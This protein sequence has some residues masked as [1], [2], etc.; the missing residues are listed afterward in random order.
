MSDITKNLLSIYYGFS[1]EVDAAKTLSVHDCANVLSDDTNISLVDE[2]LENKDQISTKEST[3][4]EDTTEHYEDGFST[5]DEKSSIDDE[6]VFEEDD[7]LTE[8]VDIFE[9]LQEQKDSNNFKKDSHFHEFNV[10]KLNNQ[11][12]FNTENLIETSSYPEKL[13]EEQ[14][15]YKNSSS[16][17]R[18]SP[19]KRASCN[20]IF[21]DLRGSGISLFPED[22]FIQFPNL[23]ML[24]LEGNRLKELPGAIFKT[25]TFLQWLDVRKNQLTCLPTDIKFHPNLETILIQRNKMQRLGLELGTLPKLR[26]LQTAQNPLI[27]PSTEILSL[28]STEI[29]RY[30][31][32]EWNKIHREEPIKLLKVAEEIIPKRSMILCY[33]P[34]TNNK[35]MLKVKKKGS[36]SKAPEKESIRKKTWNYKPSNRYDSFDAD[37]SLEGRL[38]W[39]EK[40][41]EF[42]EKRASAVQKILDCS[43]LRNWRYNCSS[44]DKSMVKAANRTEGDIPFA[45]DSNSIAI[46]MKQ[47]QNKKPVKKGTAS[48]IRAFEEPIIDINKNIDD[49]FESLDKLKANTVTENLSPKTEKKRLESEIKKIID[50]QNSIK[51]LQKHNDMFTAPSVPYADREIGQKSDDFTPSIII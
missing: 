34:K 24:Y 36:A 2:A 37:A 32:D 7:L 13:N 15:Q 14:M 20:G 50:L 42:L 5:M 18:F 11:E 31:R 48:R 43:T 45:V 49:I 8:Y 28:G 38:L 26:T 41:K 10:E 35:K 19:K 6:K 9:S 23:K 40:A 29:L 4:E 39:I 3:K 47:N 33:Q 25:L 12:H 30:L 27:Y 17:V 51:H 46:S 21:S 1:K 44:F 22:M 16:C